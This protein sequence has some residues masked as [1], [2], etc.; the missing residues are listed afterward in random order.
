M[1][2]ILFILIQEHNI[3]KILFSNT[4]SQNTY[5]IILNIIANQKV[6]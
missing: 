6:S 2:R 1:P 4:E 3:F 5:S